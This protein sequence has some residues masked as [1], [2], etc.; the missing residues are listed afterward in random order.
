M[1]VSVADAFYFTSSLCLG[2]PGLCSELGIL[3][4]TNLITTPTTCPGSLGPLCRL[5]I[6]PATATASV[7][8]L[9]LKIVNGELSFLNTLVRCIFAY[10]KHWR[11]SQRWC[12]VTVTDAQGRRHSVDVLASSTCDA[13]HLYL[14]H[15]NGNPESML[16]IPT[17]MT[18]FEVVTGGQLYR[19]RGGT[20]QKWIEQRREAWKGPRG[21]FVQKAADSGVNGCS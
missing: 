20:L 9:E 11:M 2:N 14:T 17:R 13:A 10:C 1:F 8:L 6:C 15:A 16:P 7:H 3:G 4:G 21:A 5:K 19:V 12:T 18:I